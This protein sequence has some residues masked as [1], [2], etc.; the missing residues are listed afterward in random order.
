MKVELLEFGSL[1]SSSDLMSSHVLLLKFGGLIR[2]DYLDNLHLYILKAL[3]VAVW[4][5]EQ[6]RVCGDISLQCP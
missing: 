1:F 5:F 4:H 2:M 6:V 3:I